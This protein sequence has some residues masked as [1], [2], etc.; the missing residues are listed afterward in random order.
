MFKT[1]DM[2]NIFQKYRGDRRR[3]DVGDATGSTSAR[4]R[5]SMSRRRSAMA[6]TQFLHSVWR[7]RFRTVNWCC[8]TPRAICR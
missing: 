7:W 8:S 3:P 1:A 6:A 2:L 4:G 5:S